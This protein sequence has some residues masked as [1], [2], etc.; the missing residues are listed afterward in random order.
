MTSPA[1]I[2]Y[3]S[4]DYQSL[5]Q[6]M[7]DYA[8]V[9]F[10]EWTN[11]SEGDFGVALVELF[12]YMGDILSYYQDR[13]SAEAYIGTAVQRKSVLDISQL[14]AYN[15]TNAIAATGSVTFISDPTTI[16]NVIVPA[17]T[18]VITD[19][20]TQYDSPIFYEVV[21]DTTVILGGGTGV[22]TVVEG[23][24]QG[25]NQITINQNTPYVETVTVEDLGIS[26]G[27][28]DQSMQITKKPVIEGTIRIFTNELD[29]NNRTVYV[30]WQKFDDLID[31]T[32]VDRGFSTFTDEFNYTY[33]VFG[34]SVS[35]RIPP[36]LTNLYVH[37][38]LG[39][40][41]K[42]NIAAN[43]ITDVAQSIPNVTIQS[44]STMTGGADPETTNQIRQNAPLAFRTQNRAVTLQDYADLSLGVTAVSKAA[45]VANTFASVTIY[46]LGPAGATATQALRD[47]VKIYLAT[48]QMA[49]TTVT[50]ANASVIPVNVGSNGTPCTLGVLPNYQRAVILA[51]VNKAL[52]NYFLPVNVSFGQRV[53]L[54]D[55]Y[56]TISEVPGVD[57]AIIPLLARNDAVQS[58]TNDIVLKAWE[59]PS[60]GNLIFNVLGGLG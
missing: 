46:I 59:I 32:S 30:E 20:I 51:D 25:S 27:T 42:G 55:I 5:R 10:P 16:A 39:G 12:S 48:R 56:R 49:G 14:L 52:Q 26:D 4:R 47:S 19:F 54:S 23:Q 6:S 21:A 2:D 22:A 35:G 11:R 50:V 1:N 53:S 45:A 17:G 44:S 29:V 58:G 60:A 38:R 41:A 24:T 3:T 34:D 28:V 13:T 31:A 33:I 57:Y 8:N 36:N 18:Q 40:G 43:S 9:N 37:Y 7:L 15:P